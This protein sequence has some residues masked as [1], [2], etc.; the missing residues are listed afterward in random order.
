MT[1]KKT[2]INKTKKLTDINVLTKSL[3]PTKTDM[4][5]INYWDI[6]ANTQINLITFIESNKFDIVYSKIWNI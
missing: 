3:Y 4:S 5:P 6:N 1:Q 2:K